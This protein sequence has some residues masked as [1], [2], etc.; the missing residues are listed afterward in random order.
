MYGLDINVV[1]EV[2]N[3]LENV[4]IAYMKKLS[5]Q[6]KPSTLWTTYSMLR[7]M[8]NNKHNIDILTYC[9]LRSFLKL[10][11]SGYKSK[12]SKILTSEQ[13]KT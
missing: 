12:K 10:Q 2:K 6:I 3:I 13:T 11:S 5:Q 7:T 4:L 8:L 9:K 1:I